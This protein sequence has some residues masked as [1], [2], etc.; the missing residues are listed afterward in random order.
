MYVVLLTGGLASGKDTVSRI[1]SELGATILDAD[2]IAKEEQE[3]TAVLKELQSE[4][5]EDIID[6]SG[7]LDRKLLANRA[8]KDKESAAR[9]Q[10]IC[11]PLVENRVICYINDA[12]SQTTTGERLLII[13]IPLLMEALTAIPKL[14][15][16]KDEVI[17]VIADEKLRLKRAELRGMDPDDAKHRIALQASDEERTAISDTVFLNDSSQE[18]LQK[19]VVAWFEERAKSGAF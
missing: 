9:L 1:L 5:G 6:E 4:F 3:Q 18:A 19:Q 11:W 16:I 2:Q 10:A 12:A 14:I 17:T 8:F 7:L 13:Q 15:S